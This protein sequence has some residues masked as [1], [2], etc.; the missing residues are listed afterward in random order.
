MDFSLNMV[1]VEEI[2]PCYRLPAGL[3]GQIAH[4]SFSSVAVRQRIAQ[5]SDRLGLKN[6]PELPKGLAE[7]MGSEDPAVKTLADE[8][9]DELGRR[10]ALAF[11]TAKRV[12]TIPDYCRQEHYDKFMACRR[13]LL[14]GGLATGVLGQAIAK[15]ANETLALAGCD[16]TLECA[17]MAQYMPLLGCAALCPEGNTL[18]LDFGQ[19]YMKRGVAVVKNGAV[20][21]LIRKPKQPSSYKVVKWPQFRPFLKKGARRTEANVTDYILTTYRENEALEL[22][23]EIV[24]SFAGKAENN[25]LIP[26]WGSYCKME[27][28]YPHLR[29]R[30]E[31]KLSQQLGREIKITL[32]NDEQA[33]V[34]AAPGFDGLIVT[35]GTAFGLGEP[36]ACA[37]KNSLDN[38]TIR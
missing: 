27:L 15:S 4:R 12:K 23:D 24:I 13:F 22:T 38:V 14:G 5:D 20:E 31:E 1:I 9:A 29:Q 36:A 34:Y 33:A 11:Y 35:L 2:P 18:V 32:I 25:E 28:C 30:L 10:L 8:I 37:G 16:I 19:T 6:H 3:K 26:S 17:P 21:M 7:C